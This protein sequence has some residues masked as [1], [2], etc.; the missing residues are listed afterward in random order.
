M[1]VEY[2]EQEGCV[3]SV[4]HLYISN[5]QY[6]GGLLEASDH[7]RRLLPQEDNKVARAL[8]RQEA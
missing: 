5:C 3:E 7:R 4:Q 8:R 1:V 6:L 2:V